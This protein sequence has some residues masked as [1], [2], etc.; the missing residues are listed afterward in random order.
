MMTNVLKNEKQSNE[1]WEKQKYMQR[2]TVLLMAFKLKFV[3]KWIYINSYL[4]FE[5]KKRQQIR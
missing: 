2:S 3:S 1:E 5:T 4:H